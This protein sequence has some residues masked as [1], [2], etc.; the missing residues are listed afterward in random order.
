MS[1]VK[2]S[3]E[4]GNNAASSQP[5]E[6]FKQIKGE[7]N[8]KF[9]KHSET[10]AQIQATQKALA[11][12]LE[13]FAP[14]QAPTQSPSGVDEDLEK[15]MYTDPAKYTQI[16]EERAVQKALERV[17][18]ENQ[19]QSSVQG[20]IANL[21]NE[22]P[23]LADQESELTKATVEILK[24]VSEAEKTNPRTYEYA[25]MKAA[26]QLDVKPRAK[27][28]KV[29]EDG[30]AAPSYNSPSNRSQKRSAD[31]IISQNKDFGKAVGVNLDDPKVAEKYKELLKRKGVI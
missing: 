18:A 23:E 15:V 20:T 14:K 16:I 13:R 8:R 1:D 28:A 31:K 25:V 9:D 17:R 29:E 4:G 26:T 24:G 22:Y 11:E 19:T 6:V 12:A 27:R 3:P 5:D 2:D 10:L 7:M 21:A 30:L